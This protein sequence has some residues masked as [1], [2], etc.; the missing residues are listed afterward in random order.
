MPGDAFAHYTAAGLDPLP[1]SVDVASTASPAYTTPS[2]HRIELRD[3]ARLSYVGCRARA[4]VRANQ[5]SSGGAAT[6]RLSDGSTDLVTWSIDL[7]SGTRW[8]REAEVDISGVKGTAGLFLALD[9][10]T[11]ADAGTTVEVAGALDIHHPIIL[12]SGC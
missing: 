11:A 2:A 7:S 3:L 6:L 12:L 10:T 1:E 8:T 5:A 9:V 4:T